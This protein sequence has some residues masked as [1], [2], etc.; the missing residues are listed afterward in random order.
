M[1]HCRIHYIVLSKFHFKN[2]DNPGCRYYLHLTDEKL[3][4]EE[5]HVTKVAHAGSELSSAFTAYACVTVQCSSLP[6]NWK[7]LP[8]SPH[9]PQAEH[10]I[11]QESLK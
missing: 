2:Y 5:Y 6:S 8:V 7:G 3:R 1:A 10:T 9:L 11:D 4:H